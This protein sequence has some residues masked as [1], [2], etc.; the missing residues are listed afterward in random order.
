MYCNENPTHVILFWELR[1]LSPNFHIHVSVSDLYIPRISPHISCSR[2]GRS[3]LGIYKSLADTWMWKLGLWPRNAFAGNICFEFSV[4]VLC[5][6]GET[7]LVTDWPSARQREL[8][9]L[10]LLT[11]HTDL[12]LFNGT[13]LVQCTSYLVFLRAAAS[14]LLK[15]RNYYTGTAIYTCRFPIYALE[16]FSIVPLKNTHFTF[17]FFTFFCVNLYWISLNTMH[18]F[19]IYH[20]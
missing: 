7:V 3:I 20:S 13:G 8:K 1:V 16:N 17:I 5:S 9:R 14:E 2:I 6:L 19:P 15:V 11:M 4:L 18:M 10:M 12:L